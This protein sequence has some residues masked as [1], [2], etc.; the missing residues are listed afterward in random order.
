[1]FK[2]KNMPVDIT[3]FLILLLVIQI[4][5]FFIDFFISGIYTH[6]GHSIETLGIPSGILLIFIFT[7]LAIALYLITKGFLDKTRWTRKF[8]IAFLI[9]TSLWTI[10]GIIIAASLIFHLVLLIVYL[11]MIYYLTTLPVKDYFKKTKIFTYG[12]YT[13]YKRVVE[14]KSGKTVTIYFFS[15][16]KPHSGTPTS[17]PEGYEVGINPRSSLPYLYK[18][19]NHK[20][21]TQ[22]IF[23]YKDYTLYKRV[24]ELK[25]GKTVTIHFFSKHKPH[26]GTP[27]SMPEGYDVGVNSRSNLPYLYKTKKQE[28]QKK[29]TEEQ[30][31][32]N[33]RKPSNVIY[34]VSKPQPGQVKGDWAVRGHGKIYSHH[35][36]KVNA[37]KQAR[38]IAKEKKST[39]LV[40]NTD[41]TFRQ[42]FKPR[43]SKA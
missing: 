41:G 3:L 5:Y 40:Q 18:T 1:M 30:K 37:V 38:K 20:P 39:V 33:N 9:W 29:E 2:Q 23:T 26:S 43:P 19:K 31:N 34:V 13:L 10:W 21:K 24:V 36:T 25:S 11:L 4:Y 28:T 32:N 12:P 15:K 22:K 42:S 14:L 7:I 8:T 27:T 16:H 6:Y 35:R 17:K